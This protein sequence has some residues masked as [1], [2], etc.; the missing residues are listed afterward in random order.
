VLRNDEMVPYTKIVKYPTSETSSVY[1]EN[2]LALESKETIS[3]SIVPLVK[4]T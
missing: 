3:E 4:N 2:S 1:I